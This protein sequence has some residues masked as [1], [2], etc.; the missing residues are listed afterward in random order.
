MVYAIR[1]VRRWPSRVLGVLGVWVLALPLGVVAHAD[2]PF[3]GHPPSSCLGSACR[4]PVPGIQ[5]EDADGVPD[6]RDHCPGTPLSCR[7]VD[8][9]GCPVDSDGDGIA[10]CMDLCPDSQPAA[11]VD[12]YGCEPQLSLTLDAGVDYFAFDKATLKPRMK[13][14]LNDVIPRLQAALS[15]PQSTRTIHIMGHTDSIGSDAYNLRLSERRAQAVANY[16]SA[17]G[18]QSQRVVVTGRGEREPVASNHTAR[19]RAQNRR[20]EIRVY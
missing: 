20:V 12:Q 6:V 15:V 10:D 7:P 9:V 11:S 8:S 2:N 16:L 1:F 3:F 13:Q 19:G 4:G 5:D 17:H 18:L 14:V